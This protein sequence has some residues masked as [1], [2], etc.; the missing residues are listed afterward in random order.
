MDDTNG[1]KEKVRLFN[2]LTKR[3]Y[4]EGMAHDYILNAELISEI[5]LPVEEIE[6]IF[7]TKEEYEQLPE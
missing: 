7:I 4:K 2:D 1:I 6:N 5:D 3:D